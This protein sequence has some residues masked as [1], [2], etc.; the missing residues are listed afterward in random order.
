MQTMVLTTQTGTQETFR[1]I[2]SNPVWDFALPTSPRVR[3]PAGTNTSWGGEIRINAGATY[4]WYYNITQNDVPTGAGLGFR[5]AVLAF[6]TDDDGNV[7]NGPDVNAV[8]N[9]PLLFYFE[10]FDA[11]TIIDSDPATGTDV[12]DQ[13]N[14]GGAEIQVSDIVPTRCIIVFAITFDEPDSEFLLDTSPVSLTAGI[15]ANSAISF[16]VD[17]IDGTTSTTQITQG[18]A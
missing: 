17:S 3:D 14:V 11:E 10:A 12:V 1:I 7:V 18:A 8:G 6:G 16:T 13:F 2:M 9:R 15:R 5:V 4:D